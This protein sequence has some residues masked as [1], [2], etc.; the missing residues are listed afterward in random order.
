[1]SSTMASVRP[2][3]LSSARIAA[4]S[5][6]RRLATADPMPAPPAPV[7]SATRPA[8]RSDVRPSRQ[9]GTADA[10]RQQVSTPRHRPCARGHH[11]ARDRCPSPFRLPRSR[12]RIPTSN[13]PCRRSTVRSCP[14]PG[15]CSC[16]PRS[17]DG[18]V[19]RAGG[20][21]PG[22]DEPAAGGR[23]QVPWV[24]GVVGLDPARDPARPRQQRSRASPARS[25]SACAIS[26]IASP[27]RRGSSAPERLESLRLLAQQGLVYDLVALAKGHLENGLTHRRARPGAHPRH[28]PSRRAVRTRKPLG[29]M[30]FDHGRA[31]AQHPG[32]V[33]K[34]SG[35]DPDRRRGRGLPALRRLSSSSSSAR[36]RIMW[37]SNWP[38]T[39]LARR[40]VPPH[41]G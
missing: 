34:F 30:G 18:T 21:R 13:E 41:R 7:T 39:R 32:C 38:A 20:Q 26:S 1:M 22:R 19:A 23:G 37:A 24:L 2:G 9:A 31:R 16:A 5:L 4:P 8:K 15:T 3:W 35:L 28:R 27:I 40:L 14:R 29:A 25:W 33:V 11:S 10:S 17:V 6:A 36:E 12:Q